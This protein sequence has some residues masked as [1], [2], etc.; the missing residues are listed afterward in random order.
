MSSTGRPVRDYIPTLDGWRALSITAVLLCH[1]KIHALGPLSTAWFNVHGNLG[2]DVFFAISGL[3]ICSRLLAEEQK[4]GSISIHN[5]YIRRGFRILPPAAFFLFVLYLLAKTIHFPAALPEIA[6]SLLFVRNY[7]FF[8][9]HFQTVYPYYTSHFWS[10]A[11]EEHFYLLLPALL[12]FAPRRWRVPALLTLAVAVVVHR[13]VNDAHPIFTHTDMR[14]DALL[15]P[16]AL[17]ILLQTKQ[18]QDRIRPWLRLW[19]LAA[20]LL[21]AE[22]THPL[23]PRLDQTLLA[24]LLPFFILG[25]MLRP[26]S[27]FARFLELPFMRYIGRLSYSLYLWQQIF[28]IGHFGSGATV[29][30]PFQRWPLCLVTTL[31]AALFSYYFVERPL[32]RLGH[33]VATRIVRPR[34]PTP[35]PTPAQA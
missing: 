4:Y 20:L 22:I 32:I 15:V 10:L 31:A 25:T 18:S 21:I 1:D 12:V 8:F 16:A 13:W 23:L 30:G 14:L 9:Q 28:F 24:W 27:L 34:T 19:P 7:T 33:R 29:L 35:Q 6:A 2:V 17:A 26:H 3:L 11:I 5:F